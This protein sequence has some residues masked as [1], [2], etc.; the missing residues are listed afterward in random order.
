MKNG[1][2]VWEKTK[3]LCSQVQKTDKEAP[4]AFFTYL[5]L[6]IYPF[7]PHKSEFDSK[8][9]TVRNANRAKM[10]PFNGVSSLDAFPPKTYKNSI[11]VINEINYCACFGK[12]SKAWIDVPEGVA[13]PPKFR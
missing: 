8:P 7:S 2:D 1:P 4:L 13:V 5:V 12:P 10:T 3:F 9:G 6:G 11:N